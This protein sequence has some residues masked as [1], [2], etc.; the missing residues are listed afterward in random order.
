MLRPGSIACNL[1]VLKWKSEGVNAGTVMGDSIYGSYRDP[2][3]HPLVSTS[4][5][6]GG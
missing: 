3:C 1:L 5:R 4:N 2:L 6:K